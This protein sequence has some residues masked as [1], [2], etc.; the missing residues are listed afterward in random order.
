ML[1]CL[2]AAGQEHVVSLEG[3]ELVESEAVESVRTS[4]K[5]ALYSLVEIIEGFDLSDNGNKGLERIN[6]GENL[7]DEEIKDLKKLLKSL[8]EVE[9]FYDCIGGVIG[10][11]IMVLELLFQSTFKKQTTNWSQHIKESMECQFLEIHAP[12]GL[13]LSKNTEYA[14][15]AALW[16]IEGLPDLGEIYP[17]GGSADRLGLV[18]PD[19]GECLPAAMLPYC[20]RTLLE[21]LIRDLQAREFLYFKIYGKQCITP[22]A[23]MTSS[24]K[25][26]HEHITSLCERLSWFGRA[27]CSSC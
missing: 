14:S 2:V 8:G 24:A 3:F 19:T 13:D 21:G 9:E 1:K 18:D 26:N 27:S 4:V 5:S 15:Q 23:I 20:G 7:T 22:V 11:Q 16:G 17:L 25:N 6:Y 10:Y 12:S